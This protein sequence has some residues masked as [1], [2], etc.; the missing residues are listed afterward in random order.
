[1][2]RR[3]RTWSLTSET[4][5][6]RAQK[7]NIFPHRPSYEIIHISLHIKRKGRMWRGG[8]EVRK[9]EKDKRE[10]IGNGTFS[11][12]LGKTGQKCREK[13]NKA[14]VAQSFRLRQ[15]LKNKCFK[16]R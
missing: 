15:N 14:D 11:I 16:L 2:G 6:Q 10:T 5:T 7:L 9:K 8:G 13:V 12:L 4:Q 1:M 3:E